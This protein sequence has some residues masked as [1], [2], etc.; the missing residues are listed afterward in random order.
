[1]THCERSDDGRRCPLPAVALVVCHP[2]VTDLHHQHRR[3]ADHLA[4]SKWVLTFGGVPFVERALLVALE[5]A[6]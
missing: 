6:A 1:V 2:N 4:E 3:C 5:L